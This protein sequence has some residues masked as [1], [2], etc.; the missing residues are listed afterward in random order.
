V[1]LQLFEFERKISLLEKILKHLKKYLLSGF[2]FVSP[3]FWKQR[4]RPH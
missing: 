1:S 2:D 3:F 4:A